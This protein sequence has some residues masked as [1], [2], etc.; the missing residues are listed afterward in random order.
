MMEEN[1]VLEKEE[2]SK[3]YSEK[4]FFDKVKSVSKKAGIN[5]IYAGLLL[6]YT[7]KKPALPKWAKRTIYGALGYFIVP[8]DAI[9]DIIPFG[10]YVDDFGAIVLALGAVAMFID[11][12]I[13]NKAKAKLKEWFG[14]YD[15][16]I[17]EEVDSKIKAK[18]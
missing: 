6:L 18:V 9:A 15:E 8:F 7:L 4:S 10:G 17:I 13:K 11:E 3:S 2:Y 5:I 1:Q 16:K 14:E 12:E